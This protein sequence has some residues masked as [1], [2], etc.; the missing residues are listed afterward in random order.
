ML[1]KHLSMKEGSLF[2]LFVTLRSANTYCWAT[3]SQHPP[4][5]HP[6]DAC[7]DS[8]VDDR[9]LSYYSVF[10]LVTHSIRSRS[11]I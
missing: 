7:Y 4:V 11:N 8:V 3:V 2:V 1:E 9:Q 10:I 5:H 6:L